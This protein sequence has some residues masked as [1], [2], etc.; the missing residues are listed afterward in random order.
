MACHREFFCLTH[1]DD[2][3][4]RLPLG[5]GGCEDLLEIGDWLGRIIAGE[6][7]GFGFDQIDVPAMLFPHDGAM[8]DARKLVR[9]VQRSM[10]AERFPERRRQS[11]R[12]VRQ[13]RRAR[14]RISYPIRF[15]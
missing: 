3:E 7:P 1:F 4:R 14:A 11:L 8:I 12:T 9:D 13:H 2:G 15:N 10:D 6:A 5:I